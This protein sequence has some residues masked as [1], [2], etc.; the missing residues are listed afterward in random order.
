ML[1]PTIEGPHA[2]GLCNPPGGPAAPGKP[3]TD[4][5]MDSVRIKAW[6]RPGTGNR[7]L[8]TGREKEGQKMNI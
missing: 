2:P 4:E 5:A 3:L 7:E 1:R 8:G 6:Q